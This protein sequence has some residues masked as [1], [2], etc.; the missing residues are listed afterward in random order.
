MKRKI[1]LTFGILLVVL[2][3]S[4]LLWRYIGYVRD[5]DKYKRF[6]LPRVELSK[7]E[8]NS[9]TSEKVEM[10]A[11]MEIKNQIPISFK[12][13]SLQYRIFI[14]GNEV[15]KDHYKKSIDL[16][17]ND[18]SLISLPITIFNHKLFSVLKAN[19][20]ENNDSVE[21]H[22][23]VSFST[24]I[25]FKKQ[26]NIDIKKYLPL[27]HIPQLATDHI[28][29]KSLNLSHAVIQLNLTIENRNVFSIRAKDIAYKLSIEDNQ[30]INGAIPGITDIK[31]KSKTKLTIPFT[32]SF[33]EVGKTLFDLL[34]K[35]S[36]VKYKLHL[37]FMID[38]DN[39]M[40]KNSKVVI[41]S[42]GSLKSIIKAKK[43]K[44]VS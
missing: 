24:N 36:N 14:S 26:F 34:K 31:A 10:T 28:E 16:K 38:S 17:G 32:I 2:F 6:I 37:L 29:I 1:L 43:S 41:E 3:G 27:V 4:F 11:N 42:T 7:I 30:W 25:I 8:I 23:Q 33:K 5:K 13:D 44:P 22:F 9:I 39:N 35:G 19:E 15:V 40:V 12:A 21:Y 18:R 20:L